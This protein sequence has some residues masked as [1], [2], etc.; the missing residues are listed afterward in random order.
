[1]IGIGQVRKVE[2]PKY[3]EAAYPVEEAK[4][5]THG[6]WFDGKLLET[7]I[8]DRERLRPKHRVEGPAIITQKDS[9]TVILPGH[10]GLVDSYLNILIY[11]N[12]T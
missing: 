3:E 7:P 2:L 4:Y 9:T 6:A 10:Y 11:P 12:N 8:Y 5:E 1:M